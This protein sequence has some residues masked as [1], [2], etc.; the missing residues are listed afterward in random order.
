M[1]SI[2]LDYAAT[3]PLD[4]LILEEMLPF[5]GNREG[6]GNPSSV[7]HS[8]GSEA[9]QAIER[10]A[11][12]VSKLINAKEEEIVWTSGATEANN[13]AIAG[14]AQFRQ[15]RGRNII[16]TALEHKSVLSTCASLENQEFSTTYIKPNSQGLISVSDLESALRPETILVSVM[17]ANNEIGVIQKISEI[18]TLCRS[19]DILLHVDAVQT[20][21]RLPIDVQEQKIDLLSINAHKACGPKGIGA[22]Y[23]NAERISRVEPLLYGGSQQRGM[24]PG[25]LPTHQIVGMGKTMEVADSVMEEEASRVTNLRKRLWGKLEELPG[26][27]LNGHPSRRISSILNVSVAGLEGESLRYALIGL[28]VAS[29]SACNSATDEPS[30]VLKSLGRSDQ[31][32]EASIRF[33]LGRYTVN[34]EIDHAAE[35]FSDAVEYLQALSPSNYLE[36]S[37]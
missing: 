28:A 21:G 34:E 27:Q 16:T 26:I 25:T 6:F 2:Y 24:R 11:L 31:L 4:P 35:V 13:L 5:M 3:T 20:I 8:F 33:S 19:K 18:G 23:L 22:L 7:T 36:A 37:I 32:A 1:K 9:S 10:A 30:Y 12:Q 15:S 17:H 29:G 14:V